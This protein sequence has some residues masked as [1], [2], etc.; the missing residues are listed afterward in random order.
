MVTQL[1]F[2]LGN[3]SGD[4]LMQEAGYWLIIISSLIVG[5]LGIIWNNKPSKAKFLITFSSFCLGLFVSLAWD[6]LSGIRLAEIL[7]IFGII[8]AWLV[9]IIGA[10][11]I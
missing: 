7:M 4:M 1:D 9:Y 5:I 6:A 2:A 10:A 3:L 8:A 11:K